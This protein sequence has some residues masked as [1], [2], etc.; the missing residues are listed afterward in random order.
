MVLGEK[1]WAGTVVDIETQ[2]ITITITM[3]PP[4]TAVAAV[5]RNDRL[6][7]RPRPPSPVDFTIVV[8]GFD[9]I[10]LIITVAQ[11]DETVSDG[12]YRMD[13]AS[14]ILPC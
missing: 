14:L 1:A 11:A 7:L 4:I 8:A 6:M 2:V 13:I 3:I 10:V 12:P 5:E 9:I